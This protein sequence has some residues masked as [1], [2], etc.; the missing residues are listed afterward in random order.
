M[1]IL[2]CLCHRIDVVWRRQPRIE[3]DLSLVSMLSEARS[4][5]RGGWLGIELDVLR[6]D[7]MS[8]FNLSNLKVTKLDLHRGAGLQLQG[9]PACLGARLS[10]LLII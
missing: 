1:T 7:R 8:G 4:S 5:H 10:R 3:M 6:A 9:N 2:Y